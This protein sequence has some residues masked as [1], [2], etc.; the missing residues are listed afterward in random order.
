MKSLQLLILLVICSLFSCTKDEIIYEN[1]HI[2]IVIEDNDPP[3]YTGITSVQIEGY[4]NRLF[5]DLLGREPSITERTQ[6]KDHL[7]S[8]EL[9]AES[10]DFILNQLITS[11]EYYQRFFTIHSGKLLDGITEQD[12]NN[13][14]A[15]FNILYNNA[16]TAGNAQLAQYYQSGQIKLTALEQT[17]ND[18]SIGLI[19]IDQ[20][21]AR[22]IDNPFFDNINMGSENFA[23]GC[24]EGL[25]NRLPTEAELNASIEMV[26]GFS[27]QLLLKDGNG[28]DGFIEIVTTVPEFYQGL[29]IDIY[30]QLLARNPDSEE[31]SEGTILL[32]STGDYTTVQKIVLVSDE[33]AGF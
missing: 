30:N 13:A 14:I 29:T 6:A 26:N 21:F 8:N 12:I 25:F 33:Y 1:E 11:D 9:T 22:L 17:I 20:F 4:V 16:I 28:K 7:K 19:S 27:A 10:R 2:N 24:F 23:I 15:S 5:I 31:M 3:P 18:Y 32:S